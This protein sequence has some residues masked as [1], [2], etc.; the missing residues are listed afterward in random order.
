MLKNKLLSQHINIIINWMNY[1]CYRK[2]CIIQHFIE[3]DNIILRITQDFQLM[4]LFEN[5]QKKIKKDFRA[6]PA[7]VSRY[8]IQLVEKNMNSYFK[9]VK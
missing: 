4:T 5:L 6:L 9:L 2:I 1:A 8:V 3:Q 7:V